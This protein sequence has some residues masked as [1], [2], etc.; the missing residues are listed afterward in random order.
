MGATAERVITAR[1][2]PERLKRIFDGSSIPMIMVDGERRYVEVNTPARLTFRLSLAELRRLRID[3]LTPTHFL[4]TLEDAWARLVE[5]GCVAGPYEVAS[6]DGI[7]R[8]DV[9]Y[10]ALADAL[11]GL[12]LIAFAPADWP[13]GELASDAQLDSSGSPGLTPREL[14]VLELAADGFNGPK[15]AEELV[16]SVATVRSHFGNIYDKLG[17][18]DRASAVAKAM[19][20]GL[21]A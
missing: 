6:P 5:T 19:R 14:Q 15:I 1:N 13:D 7:S 9:T 11:P 10:Y 4:P 17:V 16:V 12:H 18:G 21:I 2:R 8:L 20:L 3:D